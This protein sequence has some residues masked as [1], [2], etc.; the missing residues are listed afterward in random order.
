MER[1]IIKAAMVVVSIT[2]VLA[3]SF[4][5]WSTLGFPEPMVGLISCFTTFSFCISLV[6]F[7]DGE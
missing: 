5:F 2:A 4:L 3:G 1:C 6:V 7:C